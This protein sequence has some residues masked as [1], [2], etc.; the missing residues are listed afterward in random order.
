MNPLLGAAGQIDNGDA[1]ALDDVYIAYAGEPSSN[2]ENKKASATANYW[3]GEPK[4]HHR[5][6][7]RT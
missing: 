2:P 5:L 1:P 7:A 4:P 3:M 6:A